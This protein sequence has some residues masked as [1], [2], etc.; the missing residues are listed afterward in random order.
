MGKAIVAV[1]GSTGFLGCHLVE[2]LIQENYDVNILARDAKK[3]EVFNGRVNKIVV[4]D[5]A[6]KS[7]LDELCENADY[8]FHL[9]SNFR[10]ASG[11][12]ES[13]Q[14]I[15]V[16]GTKVA[17]QAAKHAKVK[18]FIHCSTIGVHGNVA[19][20]PATEN[21]LFA[22][23]DL[24]QETKVESENYV[25]ENINAENS[26]EIVIIRPTSM[27]GP[28]DMRMLKMFK[29]LKKKTFFKVGPCSENFHAVYIDD[30]VEGFMRAM[31]VSG[32]NGEA[33]FIGGEK[34]LP[35]DE[36]IDVV[37]KAVGA[38]PPVLRFPYWLFY[39]AA[40]ACEKIFV[41]LGI[42]PPLHVRRV[43]FFKNN[44][45]F[46]ISKAKRVLNY[47]PQVRLEDGMTKTAKWYQDNGYL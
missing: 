14:H 40:I 15:N 43:R 38:P 21:S 47:Q 11:S 45:A 41:P 8:V 29:M 20:S 31:T 3:T 33:F 6:D 28:G 42:E 37:A 39:Y 46:D 7:K 5:I 4:G 26:P 36:Y 1:T 34:Y 19:D 12:K 44:R 27:Y 32:I 10:T 23:G 16:K 25:R 18:R 35:L 24:Y 30:V 22:P 9:V 2:R 17:F 13:Y